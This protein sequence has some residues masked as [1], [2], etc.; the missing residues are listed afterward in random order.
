MSEHVEVVETYRIEAMP[1]FD[2]VAQGG[3]NLMTAWLEER[4]SAGWR[5]VAFLP[6]VQ[7]TSAVGD[8]QA[9]VF[10]RIDGRAVAWDEDATRA[11][12]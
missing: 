4:L 7:N 10:E 1:R 11:L 8:R 9:A 5:L 6:C 3:R 12:R 2:L